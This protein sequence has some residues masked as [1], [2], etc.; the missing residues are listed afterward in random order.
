MVRQRPENMKAGW[1]E[2]NKRGSVL[3]FQIFQRLSSGRE[4]IKLHVWTFE[5]RTKTAGW[6]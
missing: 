1:T 6:L 4:V 5:V 2:E 3:S